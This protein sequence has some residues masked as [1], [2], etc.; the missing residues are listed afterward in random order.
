MELDVCV[1][2]WCLRFGKHVRFIVINFQRCKVNI[3]FEMAK[4]NRDERITGLDK[5]YC[6]AENN[7]ENPYNLQIQYS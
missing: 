2:Y 6:I 5:T 1:F 7:R 3:N 4:R